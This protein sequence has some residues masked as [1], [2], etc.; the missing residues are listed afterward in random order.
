MSITPIVPETGSYEMLAL[1]NWDDYDYIRYSLNNDLEY[2]MSVILRTH[3]TY[4]P[5]ILDWAKTMALAIPGYNTWDAIKAYILAN[6]QSPLFDVDD[7]KSPKVGTE[8][9]LYNLLS[10]TQK[11]SYPAVINADKSISFWLTSRP[12]S[13]EMRVTLSLTR[14]VIAILSDFRSKNALLLQSKPTLGLL[15]TKVYYSYKLHEALVGQ[16]GYYNGSIELRLGLDS[17]FEYWMYLIQMKLRKPTRQH[18]YPAPKAMTAYHTTKDSSLPWNNQFSFSYGFN[19]FEPGEM[20]EVA[21]IDIEIRLIQAINDDNKWQQIV[22]LVG[23]TNDIMD[24]VNAERASLIKFFGKYDPAID[25]YIIQNVDLLYALESYADKLGIKVQRITL[26]KI[27]SAI[28][29]DEIKKK[30][31]FTLVLALTWSEEA[32]TSWDELSAL[33]EDM[34]HG[35]QRRALLAILLRND[36]IKDPRVPDGPG[37]LPIERLALAKNL[38]NVI[39]RNANILLVPTSCLDTFRKKLEKLTPSQLADLYANIASSQK[40]NITVPAVLQQAAQ[41]ATAW[42]QR[43]LKTQKAIFTGPSGHGLTYLN[44]FFENVGSPTIK[45]RYVPKPEE[46][47]L[48][49]LAALIGRNQH[50]TYDEVMTATH[51]ISCPGFQMLTYDDVQGYTDVMPTGK[52]IDPQLAELF[53]QAA[54]RIAQGSIVMFIASTSNFKMNY[55]NY[56]STVKTWYQTVAG[57]AFPNLE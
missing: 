36:I 56:I 38:P 16:V 27:I 4:A 46:A 52:K 48:T 57:Q 2:T 21:V 14:E 7:P 43:V 8:L 26:C 34:S 15:F 45:G 55:P 6:L 11:K 29:H 35:P 54:L 32:V 40:V 18:V 1:S 22:N 39:G 44:L 47:R 20:P 37:I 25:Q 17:D 24:E 12:Q 50:H 51:G 28:N 5:K 31:F 10:P 23:W 30:A 49:I 41:A 9:D 33:Y 19:E 53:R 3:P 42:V 13:F